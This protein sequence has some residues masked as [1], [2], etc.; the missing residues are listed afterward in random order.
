MRIQREE[1]VKEV[2]KQLWLAVPLFSVGILQYILQTI[3]VMFVG[4]LGT[5]S[6]SAA[7][8]ATSFASVTGFNLLMGLATALD[9]FCG[10][11]NGAGQYHMLGIH[12]QRSMIVVLMMSVFLAIIWANTEPI[13]IAMHQ[14]KAI[15]K[16]A[17]SY[18]R[19]MIPSLFAYGLLQCFLKFLQTQNIV[20]PMVVT[21][22][23]TATLHVLLCWVLVFKTRLGSRGAALSN[24]ICYWVNA[25]LISM[26]VKFSSS[27]KQS[28]TGF[29][30]SALHNLLDFLKL[31]V[32]ST[33]MH[34]LKVWT[35]ELMVLMS[36][37]LPNP[38]LET[39]VLS[40]CLN[41]FG[42]AWMIPFG[43]SAAISVRVS[44]E[45]DTLVANAQK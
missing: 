36:G 39:S 3:S 6:L 30:K 35:F 32:P 15:S 42:L 2:K 28:W 24:S 26:Y 13:L 7:S 5:L 16:E 33:L 29:S 8:M 27:C 20:F 44:N 10:Q 22:A 14:N 17:G 38:A 1:V 37:L 45:L 19:F 40:I 25:I 43:F 9:T 11:S 21:S 18:A 34:C 4:H 31:A 41:T 23:I 12:M